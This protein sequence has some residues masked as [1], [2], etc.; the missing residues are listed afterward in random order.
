[1]IKLWKIGWDVEGEKI[2]VVGS[3]VGGKGGRLTTGKKSASAGPQNQ[4]MVM[5]DI[6]QGKKN[7]L[8]NNFGRV[9]KFSL[10]DIGTSYASMSTRRG[11][12]FTS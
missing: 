10:R 12:Y 6:L 1:M 7:A 3:P 11:T 4:C 9:R 5:K 8:L 2:T